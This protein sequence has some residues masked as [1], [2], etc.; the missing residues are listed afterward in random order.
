MISRQYGVDPDSFALIQEVARG[1]VL[2]DLLHKTNTSLTYDLKKKFCLDVTRG[3]MYLHTRDPPII[4]R[5][6][7]SFNIFIMSINL[8]DEVNV[9][10][11]DFGLS[12]ILYTDSN[13]LLASWQWIAPEVLNSF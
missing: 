8:D 13:E 1:G 4:H 12:T 2:G 10:I 6:L 9:K 7:R 5:D 11:G 3:L